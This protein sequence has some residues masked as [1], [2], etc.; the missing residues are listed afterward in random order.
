[1]KVNS[2][3]LKRKKKKDEPFISDVIE[4]IH[5]VGLEELCGLPTEWF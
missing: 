4:G 1:M 3:L 2:V 5:L